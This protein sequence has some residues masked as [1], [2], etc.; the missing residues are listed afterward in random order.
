[1]LNHTG[2]AVWLWQFP[3]GFNDNEFLP[4]ETMARNSVSWI[5]SSVNASTILL[6]SPSNILQQMGQVKQSNN[7][8]IA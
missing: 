5:I 3:M 2:I 6:T 7:I 1:M 4:F 8:I